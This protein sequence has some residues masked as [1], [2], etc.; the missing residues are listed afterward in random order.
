M[1][2]NLSVYVALTLF[3]ILGGALASSTVA[4]A[5][6]SGM[7][8]TREP[9]AAAGEGPSTTK[10]THLTNS[11]GGKCGFCDVVSV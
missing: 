7:K 4:V 3:A 11:A 1:K 9:S 2:N 10:R 5:G 8:R 6:P